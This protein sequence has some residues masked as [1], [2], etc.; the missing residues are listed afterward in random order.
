MIHDTL[1]LLCRRPRPSVGPSRRS[2]P[3]PARW[4]FHFSYSQVKGPILEGGRSIIIRQTLHRI[5]D[6]GGVEDGTGHC[7]Q[8]C[9]HQKVRGTVR[10]ERYSYLGLPVAAESIDAVAGHD[11]CIE[12]WIELWYV[13]IYSIYTYA[14]TVLQYYFYYCMVVI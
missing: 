5:H 13:V 2:L 4:Y 1:T 6:A 3:G 7:L 10:A 8:L 9:L 11:D 12:S 14:G